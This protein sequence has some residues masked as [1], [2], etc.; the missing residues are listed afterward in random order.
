MSTFTQEEISM[1]T[2]E[3]KLEAAAASVTTKIDEAQAKV[4]SLWVRWEPYA[5][6]LG[7]AIVGGFLTHLMKL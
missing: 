3:S 4:K 6:G 2:P 7:G 1:S 5:I